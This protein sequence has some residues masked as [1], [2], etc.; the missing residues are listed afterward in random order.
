MNTT[1]A[2][3][4]AADTTTATSTSTP[5][6]TAITSAGSAPRFAATPWDALLPRSRNAE[7]LEQRAVV[8]STEAVL[9]VQGK[10]CVSRADVWA[11]CGLRC[12]RGSAQARPLPGASILDDNELAQALKL[13]RHYLELWDKVYN[14]ARHQRRLTQ[15]DYLAYRDNYEAEHRDKRRAYKRAYDQANAERIR[16]QKT[17]WA[18]KQRLA[19]PEINRAA[20]RAHYAANKE[21]ILAR[22]KV[23]GAAYRA[24]VRAAKLEAKA[25]EQAE[26]SQRAMVAAA[27]PAPVAQADTWLQR[28]EQILADLGALPA[29]AASGAQP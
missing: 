24:K 29:Q 15:A 20:Q 8:L 4:T 27:A 2:A 17:E 25:R 7:Q 23:A 1:T 22:K 16:A 19:D 18:R 12:P 11:A 28:R 14:A 13:C 5:A 21:A 9:V 10:R 6:S 26:L 3:A